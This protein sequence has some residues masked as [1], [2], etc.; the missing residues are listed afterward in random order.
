MRLMVYLAGGLSLEF[1]EIGD[2]GEYPWIANVGPLVL[3]ARAGP[4]HDVNAEGPSVAVQL[5]NRSK[6]ASTLLGQPLRARAELYDGDELFFPGIVAT[7]KVGRVLTLG[8]ES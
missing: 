3:N 8:I 2:V 6:Q 1:V 4:L 7:L 5:D